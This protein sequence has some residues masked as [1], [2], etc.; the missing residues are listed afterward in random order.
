MSDASWELQKAVVTLLKTGNAIASGRIYDRVP[1]SA[2][3]ATA[4]DS[5]FPFVAIGEMDSIPDD[6]DGASGRDDG[7]METLTLHIWSRYAGQKE[8]KEIMQQIKDKLHNVNLTVTGRNSALA[9]VRSRRSF[10]DPDGR[11]RHGVM[12]IEVIH[13][14]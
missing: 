12:S 11:T 13:R 8:V 9:W 6:V 3:S 1:D 2:S 5:E 14:S 7:E 10:M 4:P